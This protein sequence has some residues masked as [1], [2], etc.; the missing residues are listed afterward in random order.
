MEIETYILF[1]IFQDNFSLI[2]C[3]LNLKHLM[4]T[5]H[6]KYFYLLLGLINL[7]NTRYINNKV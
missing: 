1:F 4:Q 7:I 5:L 3:F 2:L 6:I